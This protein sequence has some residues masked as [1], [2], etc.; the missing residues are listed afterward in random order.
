M[1]LA[2]VIAHHGCVKT[3]VAGIVAM[4]CIVELMAVMMVMHESMHVC[5]IVCQVQRSGMT[6]VVRP[7]VPVPG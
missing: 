2:V 4:C 6:V 1:L 7:V 5:M 3:V